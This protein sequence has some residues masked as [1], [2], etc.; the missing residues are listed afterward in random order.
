M[1]LPNEQ[2][3]GTFPAYLSRLNDDRFLVQDDLAAA[4]VDP[5]RRKTPWS[6]VVTRRR[7]L[8]RIKRRRT[9]IEFAFDVATA[10]FEP[11]AHSPGMA[12]LTLGPNTLS[13]QP[14][15]PNGRFAMDVAFRK[16][17]GEAEL[18]SPTGRQHL[19]QL[20]STRAAGRR[21]I[22]RFIV[23]ALI[24]GGLV[25][26]NLLYQNHRENDFTN[27]CRDAGGSMAS[28]EEGTMLNFD[29]S[30]TCLGPTGILFV[31]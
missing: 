5:A 4:L 24:V 3:L 13:C 17:R 10:T 8:L 28:M 12:F 15:L 20:A 19:A 18:L 1:T 11:A 7:V 21:R 22:R 29:F 27:R 16:A 26:A 30:G 31:S 6:I 9:N 25:G 23:F 2:V 14:M